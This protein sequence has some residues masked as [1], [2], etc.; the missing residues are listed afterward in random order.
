MEQGRRKESPKDDRRKVI[1]K[2]SSTGIDRLDFGIIHTADWAP[3]PLIFITPNQF[4]QKKKKKKTRIPS[5]CVLLPPP[6]SLFTN[7]LQRDTQKKKGENGSEFWNCFKLNWQTPSIHID[8]FPFFISTFL[9]IQ[10]YE[11]EIKKNERN[12][13]PARRE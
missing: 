13:R 8:E 5:Q 11:K 6:P 12:G 7:L 1:N 9:N 2:D 3:S 10:E 4:N